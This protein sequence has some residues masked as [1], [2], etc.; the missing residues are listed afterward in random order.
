[1]TR[2][3]AALLMLLAGVAQA[4]TFETVTFP[5]SDGTQVSARFA[6]PAGNGPHPAI[7]LLHGCGGRDNAAGRLLD[8]HA[9]WAE[10]FLA[11]GYAV[12]LPESFQSRGKG[13]QCAVRDREILPWR[14]RRSDALAARD[15][16]RAQ[17]GI[18]PALIALLGWSHGGSTV[19]ATADAAGFAAFVAFYPGCTRPAGLPSWSP[20]APLMLLIG[21]ADDWTPAAPCRALAAAAGPR[22]SYVE[23]PGAFHG[24]DAPGPTVRLRTGLAFSV[25]GDGTAHIGTDPAARADA[26]RRV[27]EFL[28]ALLRPGPLPAT[29]RLNR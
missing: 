21:E 22:L 4:E 27:P 15:F 18:D 24:F 25:R 16:L 12:L 8:R 28:G 19:L 17:P 23:Y 14:E 2:L 3:V 29:S 10:I 9:E 20:S 26:M 6:K 5:G 1:M 11:R 13:S 7:V